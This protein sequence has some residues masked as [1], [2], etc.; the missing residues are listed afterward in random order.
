VVVDTPVPSAV[1]VGGYCV[2]TIWGEPDRAVVLDAMRPVIAERR[3]PRPACFGVPDGFLVADT[4]PPRLFSVDLDAAPPRIEP[5]GP[6]RFP[7]RVTRDEVEYFRV[8]AKAPVAEE[9]LWCLELDWS[10]AS[11]PG[12]TVVDDNGEP[13]VSY[14]RLRR[15]SPADWGCRHWHLRGC[16]AERLA[17]ISDCGRFRITQRGPRIRPDNG[18]ADLLL[19][20]RDVQS[21]DSLRYGDRVTYRAQRVSN[22]VRAF[23][24]RPKS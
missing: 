22:G 18:G 21:S 20:E 17:E 5:A 24:V 4:G 2:I 8:K 23:S 12:K 1:P 15:G 11:Q 3:P 6:T 13:F 9:I 16:P 14:P 7:Y 10:C 19:F